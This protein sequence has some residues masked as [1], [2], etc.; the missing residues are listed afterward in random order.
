MIQRMAL[1][2]VARFG[3]LIVAVG[4]IVAPPLAAAG[5]SPTTP[6]GDPDLQ[7]VWDYWT[8]TPLERAEAFAGR[9]TLTAEEAALIGQEGRA[10]ALATDRD[11]PAPGNPGAYGQEVWTERSRATALTQPSLVVDPPD[12][13]IPALTAAETSRMAAHQ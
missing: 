5:Q 12:G 10:A 11:G 3:G 6:W 7:G 2:R 9:D 8:F 13:K 4:L 1:S